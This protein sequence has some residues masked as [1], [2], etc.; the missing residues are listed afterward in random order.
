MKKKEQKLLKKL[1]QLDNPKVDEK[2]GAAD[3]ATAS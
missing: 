1:D 2:K 3:D